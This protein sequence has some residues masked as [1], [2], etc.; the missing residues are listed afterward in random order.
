MKEKLQQILQ[1][2]ISYNKSATR[3]L[4][5]T[6]PDLWQTIIETT[7]FLPDEAK[8]KQRVWHIVNDVYK[9]PICPI[10][11]EYVKWWENRY[12]GTANVN[13]AR[14]KQYQEGRVAIHDPDVKAR[15]AESIRKTIQEGR[16][17]QPT[18]TPEIIKQRIEKSKQTCLERYGVTNGSQTPESREK[19]YQKNLKAGCTPREDRSRRRLYYDE[20]WKYTEQSW[21]Q[22][23]DRINPERLNRTYNALDHI[24]SIQQGFRDNIAPEIIGHWTNL[25]VITLS[26]N[27]SKGMRCDKSKI[28]LL[29]DYGKY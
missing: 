23:F 3:Y 29:E 4:Y 27:S 20:V 24:Y 1:N 10:T 19:I 22:H 5:K 25:R 14:I 11:N 18:L 21:K 26:A 16:R 17:K 13:A 12:L 7:R 9:R 15:A 28:Q 8:A 2:D 6:Q